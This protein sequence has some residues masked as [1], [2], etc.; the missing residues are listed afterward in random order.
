MDRNKNQKVCIVTGGNSGIGLMTAVGLA[1]L[2]NRVFIGCRSI[3]KATIA[4]D[5]I[6]RESGNPQVEF[7]PLDLS[8]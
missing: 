5:Y 4:V 1:K 3:A 8:C 7:L 2:G 6:R